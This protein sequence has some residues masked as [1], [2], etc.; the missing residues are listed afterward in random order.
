VRTPA[1]AI[2][3]QLKLA[4]LVSTKSELHMPVSLVAAADATFTNGYTIASAVLVDY[5]TLDPLC[6]SVTRMRTHFPY[7]PGLL[8]F[9][10]APALISALEK[11]SPSPSVYLIDGHG[12]AHP[13][14]FGIACHVGLILNRPTIGVA[15]SRLFGMIKD[16]EIKDEKGSTIGK[17]IHLSRKKILYVSVGHKIGLEDAVKIVSNCIESGNLKPMRLAHQHAVLQR[18]S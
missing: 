16:D 17:I 13:R 2:S 8:A 5:Q 15:K 4:G 3:L 7:V 10:E 12:L 18:G 11:L 9:R 6:Y 14:R 1:E